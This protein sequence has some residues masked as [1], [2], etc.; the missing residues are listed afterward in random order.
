M[1]DAGDLKSPGHQNPCGFKSR[2]RHQ[3]SPFGLRLGSPAFGSTG[4]AARLANLHHP[5]HGTARRP[6]LPEAT[7]RLAG[8]RGGADSVARRGVQANGVA[9]RTASGERIFPHLTKPRSPSA[10]LRPVGLLA[11]VDSFSRG[12]RPESHSAPAFALQ[13]SAGP[14]AL[15]RRTPYSEPKPRRLLPAQNG[16]LGTF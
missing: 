9:C 6:A 13:A 14:A 12:S 16:S 11:A 2:H 3:P 10:G 5:G 4:S 7:A 1:A 15:C 8:L